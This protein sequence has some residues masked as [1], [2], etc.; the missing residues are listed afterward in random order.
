MAIFGCQS[1][2]SSDTE[3]LELISIEDS[4]LVL[5]S[6]DAKALSTAPIETMKSMVKVLDHCLKLH[7]ESGVAKEDVKDYQRACFSEFDTILDT[8]WK[9]VGATFQLDRFYADAARA[10]DAVRLA[11]WRGQQ[12]RP[13]EK[14]MKESWDQARS[15][16]ERTKERAEEIIEEGEI[17]TAIETRFVGD[18]EQTHERFLASSESELGLLFDQSTRSIFKQGSNPNNVRAKTMGYHLAASK[19]RLMAR[20]IY[21]LE[22]IK[23]G[24]LPENLDPLWRNYA[25]RGLNL[26]RGIKTSLEAQTQQA[27]KDLSVAKRNKARVG[28]QYLKW[29]S[30]HNA[31]K[32][33]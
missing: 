2:D 31:L 29:L 10:H 1:G 12:P 18:S 21:I 33:L 3:K 22:S 8:S 19:R 7:T 9:F 4:A 27:D 6:V 15:S 32:N 26:I 14:L 5:P 11:L 20:T 17:E 13:S 16:L 25:A 28:E 30:G 23:A 24:E